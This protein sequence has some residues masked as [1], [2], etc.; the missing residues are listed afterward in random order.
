MF[1]HFFLSPD[2]I[3]YLSPTIPTKREAISLSML[4]ILYI[5][6]QFAVWRRP[7][8]EYT[9][10]QRPLSGVHSTTMEKLAQPREGGGWTPIPIHYIY[11]HVQSYGVR[12]SL[13]GRYTYTPPISPL[14]PICSLWSPHSV[15]KLDVVHRPGS[16]FSERC[17]SVEVRVLLVEIRVT[18]W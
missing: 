16:V 18:D 15:K 2:K 17:D 5:I 4:E 14:P 6:T 13:E 7:S 9:E 8:T 3:L 11:Y 1:L 12:S 10:W